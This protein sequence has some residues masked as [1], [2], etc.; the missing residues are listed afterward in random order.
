MKLK[1]IRNLKG[2]PYL[3][4]L[5]LFEIL[6]L[7]AKIHVF[8]SSDDDR[9]L[10]THPFYYFGCILTNPGYIEHTDKGSFHRKLGHISF[11][12]PNYAHRI[13]L[14]KYDK[15]DSDAQG[16][17]DKPVITLFCTFKLKNLTWHFKCP[18]GLKDHTEFH[19]DNGC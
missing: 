16:S 7:S 1:L 19:K 2:E 18:N 12:K 15:D 4:R 14:F 5:N 6:G 11:G 10:H 8:L 13:E 17:V 9:A 3:L